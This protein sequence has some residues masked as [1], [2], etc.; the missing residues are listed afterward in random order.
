M[1][2]PLSRSLQAHTNAYRKNLIIRDTTL[3][4]GMESQKDDPKNNE[5]PRSRI[6][7]TRLI[8][9]GGHENTLVV[10]KKMN[11]TCNRKSR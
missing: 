4:G 8:F 7:Q 11:L 9:K 1:T 6:T 2:N 5:Q 3:K 10:R